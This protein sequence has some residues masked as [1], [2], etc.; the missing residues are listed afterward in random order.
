MRIL[1]TNDDGIH[2]P[3][4]FALYQALQADYKLDVVAPLTEMS[5]I[6][7][8]ISLNSPLRVTKINKKGAFFGN[9]IT[10]TP[11]DCVKIAVQEL[12]KDPPDMILSGINLGANVGINVLY[13]GTVAAATE[14]AFS[15]IPSAAISLNTLN[16]PDFL[17][18]AQFSKK[19]VQFITEKGITNGT[20]LNV[21][22][23]AVPPKEITGVRFT[24]QGTIRMNDHF[25][26]HQDPRRNLYYWLSSKMFIEDSDTNTDY[27]ALRENKISITPIHYDRT[28]NSELARLQENSCK[29]RFFFKD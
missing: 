21:N 27:M 29:N 14:G 25:E 20:T 18:A 28:C 4:L 17:F 10:G 26:Q 23:P 12:L 9:A 13:S 19:V 3:G 6:S 11:A 24:R 16:D 15:G 2:A 7:H 8:A 5:A 1:L 22:I